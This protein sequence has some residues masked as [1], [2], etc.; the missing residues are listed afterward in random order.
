MDNQKTVKEIDRRSFL[1][2]TAAMGAGLAFSPIIGQANAAKA[3]TK[4]TFIVSADAAFACP[5]IGENAKPAPIAA[6]ER[7]KLRL[8]ISLTVF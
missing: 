1:R 3:D 8:S 2:P 4:A 7:R 6:V 5:M